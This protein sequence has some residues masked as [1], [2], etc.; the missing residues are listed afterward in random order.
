VAWLAAFTATELAFDKASFV[1]EKVFR[2][3]ED[4]KLFQ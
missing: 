2:Q 4:G 3:L 1:E